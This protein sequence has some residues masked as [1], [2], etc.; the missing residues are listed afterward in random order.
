MDDKKIAILI[1]AAWFVLS[2]GIVL[3]MYLMRQR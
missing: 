3:I 2:A 1:A